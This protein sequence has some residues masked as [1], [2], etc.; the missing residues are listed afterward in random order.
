MK[1]IW[2]GAAAALVM[3]A[4]GAASAKPEVGKPAPDFRAITFDGK[5][6]TLQDL[7]GKVV[8]INFWA[9][10]CV[11]C[12]T[13]LPLLDAYYDARKNAGFAAIAI[14]TEGSI[15]V[16]NLNRLARAMK[17]PLAY[18]F[19]GKPYEDFGNGIPVSYLIDRQGVV[20]YAQEGAF[21]LQTLDRVVLPLLNEPPP[22]AAPAPA[23]ALR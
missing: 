1:A 23:A 12:Q 6:V 4:S 17:M 15:P 8:L 14:T 20:R 21:T 2:A 22:P 5:A 7:K 10:W 13:E 18:K 11:P 19:H 3:L 16:E 9:T